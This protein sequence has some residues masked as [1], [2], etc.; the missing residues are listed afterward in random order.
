VAKAAE[1]EK[2][3]NDEIKKLTADGKK[4]EAAT[5][6]KEEKALQK[7]ANE[8]KAA[9]DA[10]DIKRLDTEVKAAE[11]RIQDELKRLEGTKNPKTT[12]A[13]AI[14]KRDAKDDLLAKAASL[15]KSAADAIKKLTADGNT[16]E[17]AVLK[18]EEKKLQTLA[19]ELKAATEAD[20]IKRLEGEVKAIEEK[21]AAELR[22]ASKGTTTKAP[23]F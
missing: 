1:L 8:L 3:A 17:V 20:A 22:K 4:E 11:K 6:E 23:A 19:T 18:G 10:A 2:K 7:L 21:I 13:P 9:T 5:L 15:E 12:A 16:A 14:V